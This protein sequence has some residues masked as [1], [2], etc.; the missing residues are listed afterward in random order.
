MQKNDLLKHENEIIRIL[1][2]TAER[3]LVINCIKRTM[4]KWIDITS[5]SCYEKISED[6]LL[7]TSKLILSKSFSSEEKQFMHEHYTLIAGILPFVDDEVRRGDV[8]KTI[9]AKKNISS[10]T[11]RKYLCLYLIYQD[12]AAFLPKKRKKKELSSDEKNMR[13]ALNKFF[14][15]KHKNTLNMTYT[16]MIKEK[17]CDSEGKIVK[18]YPT[19]YQFRYFYRKY[20]KLQ[21]YYI[22]RNGLSNYQRNKRPLLGNGVREFAPNVGV[23]MIDS[24]VCDIYLVNEEGELVGRPI[25]TACIDAYSSLCCGYSLSWEGGVYSL[26]NLLL[27]VISDKAEWC[28]KFGIQIQKEEWNSS[29]LP[30]VM[31]TDMGSEYKSEIFEQLVELGVSII[32]LPPY[33]PDLKGSVEKFFDVIQNLFKPHLKGKGVIESDFQERGSHDYRKD[34]CMAI[35]RYVFKTGFLY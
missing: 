2:L 33:R 30:A 12:M 8:I 23:G 22:S 6:E 25:L 29:L 3:A 10:Q 20:N 18:S 21:T 27:N 19:F 14:Y 17:Y 16:L 15:T 28:K 5:I 1:E 34:A 9:A 4:P 11:I 7:D 24:T 35:Q 31:V 13:W 26:K 32:N